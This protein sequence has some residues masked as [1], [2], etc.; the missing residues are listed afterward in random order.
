MRAGSD[1][2]RAWL[3]FLSKPRDFEGH[4]D[5]RRHMGMRHG[6]MRCVAHHAGAVVLGMRDSVGVGHNLRAQRANTQ[7]EGY[8]EKSGSPCELQAERPP[9]MRLLTRND[10]L[11]VAGSAAPVP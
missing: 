10:H 3:L 2:N 6:S 11:R 4:R 1:N 9:V 7:H 8:G 5:L